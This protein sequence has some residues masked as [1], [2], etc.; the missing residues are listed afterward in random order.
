MCDD[1][2]T[3]GGACRIAALPCSV[4][5]KRIDSMVNRTNYKWDQ[6]CRKRRIEKGKVGYRRCRS[7]LPRPT[8]VG[9]TFSAVCEGNRVL[10]KGDATSPTIYMKKRTGGAAVLANDQAVSTTARLMMSPGIA[11]EAK[12]CL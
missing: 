12:P 8:I 10:N 6:A 4:V 7:V 11:T 3:K 5:K 1:D 2:D 9:I